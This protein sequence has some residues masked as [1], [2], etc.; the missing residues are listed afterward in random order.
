MEDGA[1]AQA[2]STPSV[3]SVG[4]PAPESAPDMGQSV[5]PVSAES[6][7]QP[8]ERASS[9]ELSVLARKEAQLRKRE[10]EL[11]ERM[12]SA[13]AENKGL[14]EVKAKWDQLMADPYSGLSELGV[15]F[16]EFAKRD[17][18]IGETESDRIRRLEQKLEQK[19]QAEQKRAEE[20][21]RA[22]MRERLSAG[23]KRYIEDVRG[24]EPEEDLAGIFDIIQDDTII[25]L[26]NGFYDK[27]THTTV[28][29]E[30]VVRYIS[31]KISNEL[32]EVVKVPRFRNQL[33]KLLGIQEPETPS[34][35]VGKDK[36][37]ATL[38]NRLSSEPTSKG[39]TSA[40]Y[41][42]RQRRAAEIIEK[43]MARRG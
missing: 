5:E 10:K 40:S 17:L 42:D 6:A 38:T 20:R 8:R 2:E 9:R 43:A 35:E 14:L 37:P 30:G 29:G 21:E 12:R 39:V 18:G 15:T 22:E 25:Q 24:Y 13:E 19:E 32:K 3:S 33:M 27:E 1:S 34:P 7:E 41:E 36:A 11:A 31:D 26:A 28:D 4:Q 23:T 16:E